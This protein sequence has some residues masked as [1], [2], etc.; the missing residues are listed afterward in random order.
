MKPCL[1]KPKSFDDYNEIHDLIM[2]LVRNLTHNTA[3]MKELRVFS[4]T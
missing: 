2:G 1:N 4:V 3:M